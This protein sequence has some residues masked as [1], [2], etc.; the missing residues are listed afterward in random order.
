M[1][2]HVEREKV[3]VPPGMTELEAYFI[4]KA[5]LH[6]SSNYLEKIWSKKHEFLE[7]WVTE[8]LGKLHVFIILWPWLWE[9]FLLLLHYDNLIALI[10]LNSNFVMQF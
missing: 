8:D 2:A 3:K 10:E 6:V 1:R 9:L 5:K 4:P 7:T